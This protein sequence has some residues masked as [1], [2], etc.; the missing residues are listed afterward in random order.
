VVWRTQGACVQF[1]VT[2]E[3]CIAITLRQPAATSLNR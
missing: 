3:T 2:R 1:V